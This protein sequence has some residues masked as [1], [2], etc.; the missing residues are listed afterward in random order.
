MTGPRIASSEA[1][2]Y[3]AVISY[4]LQGRASIRYNHFLPMYLKFS[5]IDHVPYRRPPLEKIRD[6]EPMYL[7]K[8]P[9]LYLIDAPCTSSEA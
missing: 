9:F 1:R 4:D 7:I 5:K 8:G 3:E 2:G 6:F